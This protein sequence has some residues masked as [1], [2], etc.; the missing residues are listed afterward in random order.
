M[1]QRYYTCAISTILKIGDKME[2]AVLGK[3]GEKEGGK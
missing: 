3:I 2:K 1:D